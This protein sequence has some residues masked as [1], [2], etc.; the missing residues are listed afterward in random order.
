MDVV[1]HMNPGSDG[2]AHNV[3]E[4][5]QPY[6]RVGEV[7]CHAYAD[8]QTFNSLNKLQKTGTI[9]FHDYATVVPGHI[10]LINTT[11]KS[12]G[13]MSLQDTAIPVVTA[14]LEQTDKEDADKYV[15]AGVC[16]S[17]SNSEKN[18]TRNEVFTIA[19]RGVVTVVNSTG[20]AL[21]PG[22]RIAWTFDKPAPNNGNPSI[23][24]R[25]GIRKILKSDTDEIKS[26]QFASVVNFAAKNDVVGVLLKEP[27]L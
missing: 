20:A 4:G 17:K 16:R 10:C 23:P 15:W 18:S 1:R 13:R 8:K 2:Y 24:R 26:R 3:L 12:S 21:F 19:K 22:E 11:L 14:A 5:H 6:S 9:H 7:V 25:V 27:I